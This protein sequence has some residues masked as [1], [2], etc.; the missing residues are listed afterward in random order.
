MATRKNTPSWSDV[1]TKLVDF[2]RAGLL[3]LLQDLYAANKD[4]QTFVH[5]GISLGDDVL[6]PYKTT[7]NRWLWTDVIKNQDISVAKA[8]KAIA[9]YRKAIGQPEGLAELM[10]YFCECAV[11]FSNEYGFGDDSYF[12]ALVRMF[13]QAL[14]IA[15]CLPEAQ[16]DLLWDR[17]DEV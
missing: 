11:G 2:D 3:G 9:D 12:D 16:C 13:E 14:K 5:A 10:V 8:K 15:T 1:K 6:K 7:I 4:N 17:L